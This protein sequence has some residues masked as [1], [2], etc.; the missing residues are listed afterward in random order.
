MALRDRLALTI[1]VVLAI[2]L[3]ACGGA[4]PG[5]GSVTGSPP[6]TSSPTSSTATGAEQGI[7]IWLVRGGNPVEVDRSGPVTDGVARQALTA[8][9][10]GAVPGD[11]DG[12]VSMLRADATLADVAVAD[13]IATVRFAGAFAGAEDRDLALRQ[14]VYTLTAF[15]TV[16][17]VRVVA[18][19][20]DPT[21]GLLNRT[22]V[23]GGTDQPPLIEITRAAYAD[24]VVT[25]AGTA[26]TFEANVLLRLR[27]GGTTL[28]STH[29]TATCG[30]GCRGTYEA[31]LPLPA[32]THGD[33]VVEAYE[34]SMADGSQMT[35]ARRTIP[36]P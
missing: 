32:G 23:D 5:D 8:L 25:V 1:T 36:V 16:H 33:V 18:A 22:I 11:P 20:E 24:G 3:A 6:V 21:P 4:S 14:I 28:R 35:R 29:T 7:R 2:P 26:D 31:R 30:S 17:W 13:G 12:T 27:Q 10:A 34:T 9:L 19:G 15:D